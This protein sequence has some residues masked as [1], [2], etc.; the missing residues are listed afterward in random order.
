ME[1]NTGEQLGRLEA[2]GEEDAGIAW[3][4]LAMEE[5][6]EKLRS[7]V[8]GLP[9]EQVRERQREFGPNSLPAKKTPGLGII[10]LHQ[11]LS[12]LIYILLAAGTVSVIIGELTDAVFIFAVILLNATLGAFQEWKAERSAAALQRLLSIHARVRRQGEEAEIPAEEL[13]PGDVI[14][15]ESGSRVPA[16]LRL[17]SARDLSIDESLLTGESLPVSKSARLLSGELPVSERLN[18]AFAASTVATGRS[19]GVVV[20]TGSLTEVGQIA[21]AV[22][23]AEVAKPP[24]VIRMERF[25]RQISYLV[26][27]FV[28]LLALFAHLQGTPWLDVFFMAVAL[29]VSAIPEGL[30]VAMTVALS[31][32]TTRMARRS[33]IVRKLTAVEAL[34]SCTCIASDKTGTLTVNRQ[35]AKVISLPGGELFAVSGEGYTGEGRV[36]T[37][38]GMEP[39]PAGRE[40]LRRLAMAAALCNEGSLVS[41]KGGWEHHGDAVDV[42]LLALAFKVGIIP[43]AEAAWA[44]ILGD[45]PFESERRYAARF[46][47]HEGGI[48]VAVK[49][50]AEAVLPFCAIMQ[51]GEGAAELDLERMER[52]AL[53]LAEGGYRI[54]AVADGHLPPE[55][56]MRE[57]LEER[58][59]PLTF[60]GLVGL[61]D[62]L[63]P[64]AREAVERCRRAGIKVV[65]VTGDHPTTAL[66]IAREL[67]IARSR[68]DLVTGQQLA[69]IGSADIPQFLETVRGATVFSRVAPLQKLHIVEAL[70][71]LG[72]FVAV[73]GDGVNDAPAL[74]RA[75]IGVAMG[76]GTDVAKDTA[77]I[78]VTDDNFASIQAGVEEG[79]FA[80]DNV[81]KVVYLLI[82]TGAAEIVLFTLALAAGLPLPL[83]AVQLLWLNLVTNGIQDVALA[84]EGGEPG[85]ME[86]PPRP[87]TEGV[88]NRLMVQQ[89]VVSG[90]TMGLFSFAAWWWLLENGWT[91]P[92]ARNMILLLMVL[93]ENVHVF[94]CRSEL[95]SAFKVP[96]RR[97]RILVFGVLAAQTVHILTLYTPL[98]QRVLQVAPVSLTSWA[99]LILVALVLLLVM[100]LFKMAKRLFLK[101]HP[102]VTCDAHEC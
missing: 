60:L 36:T 93:F 21:R 45:I 46:Y 100:E 83:L 77:E 6:F 43:P 31:I 96:I 95:V 61:I 1:S 63:R 32:A 89:T 22:T 20:A 68:E 98:M 79:R 30:P 85:A 57:P 86:K 58:I 41:K 64:E 72:H 37:P 62:P 25:A 42:A 82:S 92:E 51:Q 14:L 53:A 9:Q 59:P 94:N 102:P 8:H 101:S 88:F 74:R 29:A 70:I 65:M 73:T 23:A 39:D 16:D 17:I 81:R 80:Y 15:L 52:Q 47:R 71:R 24:L 78:L 55:S 10:F 5:V 49:G 84:F 34:G 38:E 97:N 13:V 40:G 26:L 27:G 35:T 33:V 67:S 90:L 7:G 11:F 3:Y 4:A 12:P 50:A 19:T 2:G 75:N 66:S 28:A 56:L 18:M 87:P 69:D 54:I 76:S 99:I 44:E 48:H 91:E